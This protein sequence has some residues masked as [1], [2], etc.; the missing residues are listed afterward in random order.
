MIK[1]WGNRQA[2]T[3]PAPPDSSSSSSAPHDLPKQPKLHPSAAN[4]GEAT[5]HTLTASSSFVALPAY[6]RLTSSLETTPTMQPETATTTTSHHKDAQAFPVRAATI[7]RTAKLALV[8]RTI[9]I[10]LKAGRNSVFVDRLPTAIDT[11]IQPPRVGVPDDAAGVSLVSVKYHAGSAAP[12][13]PS[14]KCPATTEE[15]EALKSTLTLVLVAA[16]D[17]EVEIEIAYLVDGAKWWPFYDIRAYIGKGTSGS[18]A[19]DQ[20]HVMIHYRAVVSQ[21]TGEEWKN[22]A[23]TLSLGSPSFNVPPLSQVNAVGAY[24]SSSA[25][26]PSNAS[27]FSLPGSSSDLDVEKS[28]LLRPSTNSDWIPLVSNFE[29]AAPA[30]VSSRDG[31]TKETTLFVA[32]LVL[33]SIDLEWI[34]VPKESSTAFI[35]CKITNATTY[36]LFP[37]SASVFVGN[38]F[39]ATTSIPRVQPHE[40]FTTCFGPDALVQVTR[41]PLAKKG[42]TTASGSSTYFSRRTAIYNGRSAV[43]PKLIIRDRVPIASNGRLTL[44]APA[45]LPVGADSWKGVHVRDGVRARFVQK[46]D[47]ERAEGEKGDGTIEWVCKPVPAGHRFEVSLVWELVAA[48]GIKW[49]L[50][51]TDL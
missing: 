24:N 1:K 2:P 46:N 36:D 11:R 16:E 26:T 29:I 32:E 43:L 30:S 31:S 23:L 41:S 12:G 39:V 10:G 49:T 33:E 51:E 18:G 25:K 19:G 40:S 17:V 13:S 5:V 4:G 38:T 27:G 21:T 14:S 15:S 37:G 42:T 22:V 3:T 7:F 45:D 34:V 35:Q 8:S 48:A 6:V 20:H 44:L 9:P 50:S 28:I 47:E